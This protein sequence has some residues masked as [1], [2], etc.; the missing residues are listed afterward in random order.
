VTLTNCTL[1]RNSA[2]FGGGIFNLGTVTL[3]NSTLSGNLVFQGYGGGIYNGFGFVTLT[4]CTLSGNSAIVD[5]GGG[6]YNLSGMVTVTN[7]TLRGNSA[8]TSGGG[9]FRDAGTVTTKN[10]ILAGNTAPSSPDM[11]GILNSQGHNLIGNGTG[12]SGFTPTDLVGSAAFSID[13]LLEP[14]GDYGGPTQTMRPLP[15]RRPTSAGS[16]A[17]WAASSTWALWNYRLHQ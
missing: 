9:I 1:S 3:T 2:D 11:S 5:R 10:M 14:L 15:L 6:I 16:R 12:G 17:S 7:S 8:G 13:P 4:N